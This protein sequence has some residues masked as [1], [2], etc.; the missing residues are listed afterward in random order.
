MN[1]PIDPTDNDD[2]PQELIQN[3]PSKAARRRV[4]QAS[5]ISL[6]VN[7][8]SFA[9]ALDELSQIELRQ[10]ASQLR[11]AGTR[12]IHYY[13]VDDLPQV[14]PDDVIDQGGGD[15]SSGAY[16]S[17]VRETL[18][19]HDR[20]YV[21]CKVP[22]TGSQTQ[23]T[24]S[25]EHLLTT[26]ATFEPRTRL[27]AVRAPDA[28]TA[29][30]TAQA[31]V[32]HFGL[33]DASHISF[34]ENGFRGRFEDTCVEGYS[35]VQLRHTTASANTKEI[36]VRSKE[37]KDKS[38]ADVRFDSIVTDLLHRSDTELDAAKGLVSVPTEI[39]S[40]EHDEQFHPR[41]TIRFPVGSVTFEQFVP[42]QILIGFDNIVRQSF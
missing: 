41:V 5:D 34:L 33:E 11:F 3:L 18:R 6:D 17:E 8:W 35:M 42:E 31:V 32:S 16:G 20:L 28:G 21:V 4:L 36:E 38:I 12:T 23:L 24:L 14:S 10:A 39:S 30:S 37:S 40:A 13:R 29:D 15:S 7:D 26:V 22:E 1:L 19:D 9:E 27:L 25:E 2:S